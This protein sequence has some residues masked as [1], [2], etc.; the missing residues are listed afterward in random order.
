MTAYDQS[1]QLMNRLL[2]LDKE[3]KFNSDEAEDIR[4]Q[5]DPLWLE[6]TE[7]EQ[8]KISKMSHQHNLIRFNEQLD[9]LCKRYGIK[10]IKEKKMI[11][12]LPPHWTDSILPD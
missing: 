11:T 7:E 4:S 9:G 6:L 1:V 8:D 12:I 3:G 10:V 5:G 2:D